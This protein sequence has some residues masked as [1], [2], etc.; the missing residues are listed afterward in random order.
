MNK[1]QLKQLVKEEVQNVLK[2]TTHSPV[3]SIR[4]E[5]QYMLKTRPLLQINFQ[6]L[7]TTN[8]LYEYLETMLDMLPPEV[9]NSEQLKLAFR[10]LYP[11]VSE[12]KQTEA[13]IG[14]IP[15]GVEIKHARSEEEVSQLEKDG[16]IRVDK[17]NPSFDYK[18]DKGSYIPMMKRGK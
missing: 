9:R 15:G 12:N 14:K 2:K 6:Q 8:E 1:S 13:L 18:D 17:R 3:K 10:K 7:N 5:I 11:I 4:K 16:F